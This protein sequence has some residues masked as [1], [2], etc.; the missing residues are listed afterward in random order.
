MGGLRHSLS[1]PHPHWPRGNTSPNMIIPAFE[2]GMIRPARA[3]AHRTRLAG[4]PPCSAPQRTRYHDIPSPYRLALG[5]ITICLKP[6]LIFILVVLLF[7]S[8]LVVLLA[9]PTMKRKRLVYHC[10]DG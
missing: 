8:L 3:A 5:R 4:P 1:S 6:E 10:K 2:R 7:L 9:K